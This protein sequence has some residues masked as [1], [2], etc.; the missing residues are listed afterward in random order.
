[1]PMN[2]FRFHIVVFL[3]LVAVFELMAQEKGQMCWNEDIR[4][5]WDDF[6]GTPDYHASNAAV[7]ASGISHGFS[8][9]IKGDKVSYTSKVDCYFHPNLSWYKKE[10]GDDKLLAHEQLHFDISELY[11]RKLRK[12]INEYVFTSNIHEEMNTLYDNALKELKDFQAQYDNESDYSRKIPEQRHWEK[13]IKGLLLGLK[14]YK[15]R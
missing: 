1:M 10:L 15:S 4:L 7:T 2:D 14:G 13:K 8:A 12:R 5:S 6:K 9:S 11:V 3:L